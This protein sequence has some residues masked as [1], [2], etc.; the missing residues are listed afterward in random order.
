MADSKLADLTE[1]TT[2]AGD[3]FLY[4]VDDPGGT[5]L[6]RKVT[7][8]NLA[9]APFASGRAKGGGVTFP[10]IPGV[11][12]V[13]ATTFARAANI[14]YYEPFYVEDPCV[15]D[16]L[17]TEIT[18]GGSAGTTA[19]LGIYNADED[20]QPTSLLVGPATTVPVDSTGVK[21]LTGLGQA[22]PAGRYLGAF[23]SDGA[24]TTRVMRGSIRGA[25]LG[26]ALGSNLAVRFMQKAKAY[27][28]LAD[29]G[30][31]WDAVNATSASQEWGV[32]YVVSAT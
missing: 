20:W 16:E 14:V 28:A 10:S 19:R 30:T 32:F 7:V 11:S 8:A 17:W 5:P 13:T 22:V 2:L 4:V 24:P 21:K 15:I 26:S 29:P 1:V 31:A 9:R 27:A 6:D 25:P 18:A 12:H 3:E 23:T